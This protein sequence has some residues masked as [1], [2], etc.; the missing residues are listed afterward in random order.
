MRRK[1]AKQIVVVGAG[2]NGLVAA[3][4]LKKAGY[5]VTVIE[6]KE[7][8]GGACSSA[9]IRYRGKT[10]SYPNGASVLGLMP[11]FIFKD[12]GLRRALKTYTPKESHILYFD[13]RVP[14]EDGGLTES[15][16]TRQYEKDLQKVRAL[17]IDGYRTA[18]IPTV[19][20]FRKKIGHRLTK[21]WITGSAAQLL[22]HFG[23][24]VGFE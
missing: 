24:Q 15:R 2:I 18:T 16:Y 19:A 14:A 1:I 10:Y 8:V 23:I 5:S 21:V 6:R 9:T 13:D 4:Y 11:D 7:K 20:T 17:L 12:T 3:Y 22:K